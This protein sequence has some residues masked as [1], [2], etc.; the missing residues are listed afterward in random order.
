[1]YSLLSLVTAGFNSILCVCLLQSCAV[2][3]DGDM[4][5]CAATAWSQP[6]RQAH[7][8]ALH[9]GNLCLTQCLFSAAAYVIMVPTKPMCVESFTAYPPLGRFAVRDMRQTVAVGVIKAVEKKDVAGKV[10]KAAA[11][12]K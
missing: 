2:C 4:L 11:K 10:T 12:K 1:M 6:L 3:F 5:C 9:L 7:R 8:R